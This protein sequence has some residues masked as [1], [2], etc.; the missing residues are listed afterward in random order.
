MGNSSG[1]M[2]V[3]WPGVRAR[4]PAL[5]ACLADDEWFPTP[6]DGALFQ[7]PLDELHERHSTALLSLCEYHHLARTMPVALPSGAAKE[8]AAAIQ[9]C[10]RVS[11]SS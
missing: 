7:P 5:A 8:Q 9:S 3:A 10:L 6:R 1:S 2:A 11:L 4:A